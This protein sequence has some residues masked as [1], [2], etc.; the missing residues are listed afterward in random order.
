MLSNTCCGQGEDEVTIRVGFVPLYRIRYPSSRYRVF[1]FLEPLSERGFE[2]ALIEAP[3]RDPWKRLAYLPRLLRLAVSQDVL[4]VQKRMFPLWVLGLVRRVNSRIVFDLDDATF[5]RPAQQRRVD[6]LLRAAVLVVAGNDYLADYARR[7]NEQV[8]VIPSVVDTVLYRPPDGER[9]PGDDRIVVGWIG[10]DP[11][12]GDLAPMRPVFDG[13][14]E[15]YGERVMLRT[16]GRRPLEIE[17][18]LKVEFVPWT[19]ESS[20]PALRQ[21]DI[22]IMPLDD[23]AWN[24]GKCGFKLIQY[25]AVGAAAVA[26]PVGVNRQIVREGQTGYLATTAEEWLGRLNCLIEDEALRVRMGRAARERVE[27]VYSVKA[28]LPHLVKVLEQA[29]AMRW[30]ETV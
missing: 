6:A 2:C 30:G 18:A 23:T 20:R 22:G 19:L 28:V 17:T 25:M 15:R 8:V 5:L 7:F 10:S 29:R 11:N 4:Y 1:Q 24:R 14:H 16:I 9:H 21:F 26:S 27:Q 12:R 3:Q 13:L